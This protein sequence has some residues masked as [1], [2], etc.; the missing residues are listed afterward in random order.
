MLDQRSSGIPLPRG[1]DAAW[2]YGLG[3]VNKLTSRY[4]RLCS[5]TQA[6]LSLENKYSQLT[7]LRLREKA[8]RLREIFRCNRDNPSDLEHAFAL[9][10]EVA[11]R[12]LGE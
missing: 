10:R 7:D 3:C 1:L 4:K 5:Q 9:V 11:F 2:D 8:Q 6:I 12:K